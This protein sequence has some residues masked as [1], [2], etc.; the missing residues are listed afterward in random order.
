MSNQPVDG[1]LLHGS[2]PVTHASTAFGPQSLPTLSSHILHFYWCTTR[3]SILPC[4]HSAGNS[5]PLHVSHRLVLNGRWRNLHIFSASRILRLTEIP[6]PSL[7]SSPFSLCRHLYICFYLNVHLSPFSL[8]FLL[9]LP[10]SK[11]FTHRR[12]PNL[13]LVKNC[14]C[15]FLHYFPFLLPCT[16]TFRVC[17][18]FRRPPTMG[19]VCH[20]ILSRA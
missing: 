9:R 19:A 20:V 5:T 7:V 14:N 10:F 18:I 13:P 3:N 8:S 11:H 17:S 1:L 2:W 6:I 15:L 4:L 12:S 16:C